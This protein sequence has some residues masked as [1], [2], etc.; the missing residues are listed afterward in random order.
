MTTCAIPPEG[1]LCTRDAGHDGPC[2]AVEDDT[3]TLR[4][5]LCIEL[6]YCRH[7]DKSVTET[8]DRV[9][10]LLKHDGLAG[11]MVGRWIEW[12]G[13]ECPCPGAIVDVRY[14]WGR[15]VSRLPA[16]RMTW[17]HCTGSLAGYD[18]DI[19]AYRVVQS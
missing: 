19:I 18:H 7:T 4:G 12:T 11:A 15:E 17:G 16:S 10:A 8:A 6:S 13:G 5:K 2:A 9:L 3:L 1:W 14:R